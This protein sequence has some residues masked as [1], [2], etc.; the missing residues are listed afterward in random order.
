MGREYPQGF[1]RVDFFL[2][3]IA[4]YFPTL[5]VHGEMPVPAVLRS[6][7]LPRQPALLGLLTLNILDEP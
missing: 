4:C 6:A 1:D 5:S 7:G 2:A 3:V